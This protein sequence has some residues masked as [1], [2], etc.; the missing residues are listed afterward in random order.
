MEIEEERLLPFLQ[1][2]RRGGVDAFGRLPHAVLVED[3]EAAAEAAARVEPAGRPAHHGARRDGDR[4]EAARLEDLGEGRRPRRDAERLARLAEEGRGPARGEDRVDRGEGAGDLAAG[5]TEPHRPAG[6]GVQVGAGAAAVAIGAQAV[7][8]QRV[9]QEEDHVAGAR[10]L[11]AAGG[12]RQ[13]GQGQDQG[14]GDLSFRHRLCFQ[15]R[16]EATFP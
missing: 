2:L 8:P 12:G 7:G 9:H 15:I 11:P 16:R 14:P 10:R 3:V 13:R 4:V 1:M 5:V 6:E